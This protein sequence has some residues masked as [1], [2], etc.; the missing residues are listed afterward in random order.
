MAIVREKVLADLVIGRIPPDLCWGKPEE[1]LK[2]IEEAMDVILQLNSNNDFVVI[3][4]E[5]PS[6]D[7]KNRLWV[8]LARNGSFQGFYLFVDGKWQRVFN[9]RN[10]EII[11]MFGDSRNIPEG[12]QLIDGTA[13]G[14]PTDIQQHII[15]QYKINE[16]VT[17]IATVY[18]YF[19]VRYL[20][21]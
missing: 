4:H 6:A 7:D 19:A 18:E 13:T 9:R 10:D 20:G 21:I 5:T 17:G 2:A 15:Q 3:G 11:W 8:R 16:D 1:F 14:I 12:F